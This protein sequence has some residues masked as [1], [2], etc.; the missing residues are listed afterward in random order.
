MKALLI[1]AVGTAVLVAACSSSPAVVPDS[2]ITATAER[3]LSLGDSPARQSLFSG[4]GRL[5]ALTNAGGDVFVLRTADWRL[6]RRLK[7]PDGATSG[8]FS[9]DSAILYTAGYDG[10]VRAWD[11]RSGKPVRTFEPGGGTIWT[12]DLSPDGR[13][14]ATGGEDGIV[15]LWSLENPAAQPSLLRGHERNIWEVRFSP[16]GAELSSGSFD[17]SVRQWDVA[18]GKQKRV[19]RGHSQAVVGLD[20]SPDGRMLATSGDDSVIRLWDRGGEQLRAIAAGNHAYKVDFSP[21]GQWIASAVRPRSAAATALYQ[22][23]GIGGAATPVR[24]L[25]VLDGALIAALPQPTDVA[26]VTVS[27]DGRR[28]VSADDDGRVRIWRIAERL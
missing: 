11:V 17:Y 26:S 25:R 23:T 7:H 3:V 10:K 24:L 8:A 16:D 2:P 12:L 1:F 9:P 5:L 13:R 14:M 4:D 21:D 15:R 20:Y 28:V 22:V 6:I 18:S 19:L 27:P